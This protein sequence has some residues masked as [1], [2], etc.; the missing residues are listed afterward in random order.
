MVDVFGQF[1]D[2]DDCDSKIIWICRYGC[3]DQFL[4]VAWSNSKGADQIGKGI[5]KREEIKGGGLQE[6]ATGG[7]EGVCFC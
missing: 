4:Y 7:G 5:G 6:G 2:G 1:H 3:D